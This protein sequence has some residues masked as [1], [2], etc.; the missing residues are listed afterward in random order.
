[1]PPVPT[2]AVPTP[3][4]AAPPL[5]DLPGAVDGARAD[6]AAAA[7]RITEPV[8]P[9]ELGDRRVVDVP[10]DAPRASVVTT[11]PT[12]ADVTPAPPAPRRVARTDDVA[13]GAAPRT[14]PTPAAPAV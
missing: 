14:P 4:P 1:V 11:P 8:R 7:I 3:L 5:P 13:V 2:P 10:V 9:R 12:A 6:G